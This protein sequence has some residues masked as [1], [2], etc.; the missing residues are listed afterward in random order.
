VP[1]SISSLYPFILPSGWRG[2]RKDFLG[3]EFCIS[4]TTVLNHTKLIVGTDIILLSVT[5]WYRSY[6]LIDK[7][8]L[9]S[10][11]VHIFMAAH[12]GAFGWGTRLW[13]QFAMASFEIHNHSI[14]QTV[15]RPVVD[16]ASNRN[17]CKEYL[18]GVKLAGILVSQHFHF[19]APDFSKP[20]SLELLVPSGLFRECS[21]F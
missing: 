13:V 21:T 1:V 17:M 10:A 14:F 18:K 6:N 5:V 4:F 7:N 3:I 2:M 16:W 11:P 9:P 20:R 15:L 19:Y 8:Y 12:G